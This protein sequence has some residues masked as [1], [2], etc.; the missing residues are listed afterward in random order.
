MI[1]LLRNSCKNLYRRKTRTLITLVGIAIGVLS[2]VLITSI[3][4]LGKSVINEELSSMGMGGIAVGVDSS[5]TGQGLSNTQLSIV[6]N[7]PNVKTCMPLMMDY[8]NASAH[9][10]TTKCVTLGI[11]ENATEIASLQLLHGRMLTNRDVTQGS[12]VCVVDESFAELMYQRSNIVGKTI[13]VQMGQQSVDFQVVGVVSSGGNMLQGMMGQYVPTFLY[14]PFTTMQELLNSNSYDELVL[15]LT[16]DADS[17]A[18]AT[19]LTSEINQSLGVE[20]AASVQDFVEQTAALNDIFDVVT[21][22]LALI[23]GISLLVA[24]LS[25]MTVML[26]S[27]QERTKEIGIKKAIGATNTRILLEFLVEAVLLCAT[28]SAI[29]IGF[30]MGISALGSH[31]IGIPYSVNGKGLLFCAA[32]SIAAGILFGVYPAKKAANLCPA[33]ALSC[34]H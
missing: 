20:N 32:F 33:I 22:V 4:D 16:D 29:G 12:R 13:Q 19:R 25:I 2:V 5:V 18:V 23:A 15:E 14:L 10:I 8:T 17:Q 28:G 6:E 9:H 21:I 30:G 26:M 24:G 1:D 7:D 34:D 11:N 31:L 3:G 27:V